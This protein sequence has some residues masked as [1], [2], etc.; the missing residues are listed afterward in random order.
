MV[1]Q[2]GS[3]CRSSLHLVYDYELCPETPSPTRM[4]THTLQLDISDLIVSQLI[5]LMSGG[6]E[7]A[8]ERGFCAVDCGHKAG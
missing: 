6:S 8:G 2:A 1:N 7:A 3:K 4:Y 5:Y